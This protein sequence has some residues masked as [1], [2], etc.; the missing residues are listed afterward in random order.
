LEGAREG[1]ARDSRRDPEN[2]LRDELRPHWDQGVVGEIHTIYS[3]VA[4]GG[5]SNLARK[6]HMG[7]MKAEEI[8]VQRPSKIAKKD[9][10]VISI[11]KEDAKR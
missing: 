5:L 1:G 3:G 8:L 2:G 6:A 11:S 7:K 9:T 4:S 10:I